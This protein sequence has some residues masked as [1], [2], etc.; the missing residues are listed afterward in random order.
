MA[1]STWPGV[2]CNNCNKII[3]FNQESTVWGL[4]TQLHTRVRILV[5]VSR[6]PA[7]LLNNY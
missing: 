7:P 5:P 2:K 6:Q 1:S 3:L 4:E